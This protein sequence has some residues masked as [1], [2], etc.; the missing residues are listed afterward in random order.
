MKRYD[1]EKIEYDE[2]KIMIFST[3]Y[4][5]PLRDITEISMEL[6]NYIPP[7]AKVVFDLLLNMGNNKER[8]AEAYFDGNEFNKSSFRYITVDKKS[9]I[10]KF[11]CSYFM[12]NPDLLDNSIL[13]SI[14]KKMLIKGIT[15]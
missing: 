11:S 15:I 3:S 4:E 5:T 1:F 13:N 12:K 8:Y 7:K 6:R 9:E 10:R 2:Y 14:Q